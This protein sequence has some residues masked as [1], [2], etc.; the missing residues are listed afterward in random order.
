MS[1]VNH[2]VLFVGTSLA[3]LVAPWVL[4]PGRAEAAPRN[5]DH[6]EVSGQCVT[7]TRI[8]QGQAFYTWSRGAESGSGNLPV[9]MLGKTCRPAA[10]PAPPAGGGGGPHPGEHY[11]VDGR[12]VAIGS[13][14]GGQVSYSWS[15]GHASG[16]GTLPTQMLG[17]R[18][19]PPAAVPASDPPIPN[20]VPHLQPPAPHSNAPAPHSNAPAP[21]SNAPD[22]EPPAD[23]PPD[24]PLTAAEIRVMVDAHNA[25]RAK[26]G[27]GP[28]QWDPTVAAYAQRYVETLRGACSLSHSN[29]NYGENL[30][31]WTGK[32][33]VSEAVSSWESEKKD[34]HGNGGPF[35]DADFGTSGHYTQVVWRGTTRIGC[36]RVTCA[37]EPHWVW[38]LISC[39]YDP[40]GNRGG[41][42]VY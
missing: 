8:R 18:C 28:V 40:A 14:H 20:L 38:T 24:G 37:N 21:H 3:G 33:P 42:P 11:S 4:A 26:V 41:T 22:P 34:Y 12:C 17:A 6:Y 13:V 32:R 36:G 9:A 5:G 35:T 15:E 30:A 23:V 29:A 10:A 39:N 1:Q 16:S 2:A 7:V 19:E 27:V 31:A 25:V